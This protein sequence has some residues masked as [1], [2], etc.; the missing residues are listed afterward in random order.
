MWHFIE[1][2]R[3]Y[4]FVML[5][6]GWHFQSQNECY[7][8]YFNS[9]LKT[10]SMRQRFLH[11]K[12]TRPTIE[13]KKQTTAIMIMI[14]YGGSQLNDDKPTLSFHLIVGMFFLKKKTKRRRKFE[15]RHDNKITIRQNIW[16][17]KRNNFFVIC[18]EAY[19]NRSIFCEYI[20]CI[21]YSLLLLLLLLQWTTNNRKCLAF[22][23]K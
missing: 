10:I 11:H 18:W 14:L 1:I 21:L 13:I 8:V 2:F 7:F 15:T 19:R 3:W 16:K 22:D 4:F 5:S 23:S 6:V 9:H 17:K 12:Q 20:Q